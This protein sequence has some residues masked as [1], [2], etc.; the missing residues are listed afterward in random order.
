VREPVPEPLL[1]HLGESTGMSATGPPPAGLRLAWAHESP[2]SMGGPFGGELLE[3]VAR[4]D[5]IRVGG[6]V[7]ARQGGQLV[8]VT[9]DLW[10]VT[11]A[12]RTLIDGG[13]LL[14]VDTLS[15][16][17]R[18]RAP[19]PDD[20]P[21]YPHWDVHRA[22]GASL[23]G[24][25]D[26][27]VLVADDGSVVAEVDGHFLSYV[28]RA[29]G[30]PAAFPVRR[31][32]PAVQGELSAPLQ[33][34]RADTGEVVADFPG[35]ETRIADVSGDLALVATT[36]ATI[37]LYH[38]PSATDDVVWSVV[39]LDARTG[40]ERATL[41]AISREPPRLVGT[42]GDGTVVVTTKI[43]NE[44]PLLAVTPAG[45]VSRI[46]QPG[47]Q[48][49][50]LGSR[51]I[52][53]STALSTTAMAGD[54][55][56][57][58]GEDGEVVGL[59]R[60]GNR[61]WELAAPGAAGIRAGGGYVALFSDENRRV[62]LVRASDGEVV[63][64]LDPPHEE[65]YV[66]DSVGQPTGAIG[67]H[68]G[69]SRSASFMR[70]HQGPLVG[71]TWLDLRT[72][73]P[74]VL[75]DVFGRFA[76]GERVGLN[77]VFH[78]IVTNEQGQPEP[79]LSRTQPQRTFEL[80]EPGEGFRTHQ[81]PLPSTDGT[82]DGSTDGVRGDVPVYGLA[83][84]GA[85]ADRFAVWWEGVRRPADLS[86]IVL[87]RTTGESTSV[88]GL[89]GLVLVGDLL[90][91]E[92]IDELYEVAALVAVDPV[93][94]EEQWRS[95]PHVRSPG[96][97]VLLADDDLVIDRGR[98][99][100]TARSTRD[101]T[102]QWTH[103]SDTELS[104]EVVLG[105]SHVVVATTGGELV[106]LDRHDGAVTWRTA[107]GTPV[108]SITGAG[109][110]VVVGTHDGLVIHLDDRGRE[111]QRIL[112]GTGAVH[113]VAALGDTVVAIVDEQVIGLRTDGTGITRD[114]EVDL[115]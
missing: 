23:V 21:H 46:A 5:R 47:R 6:F 25:E 92:E 100:V 50:L 101:G 33:L 18:S 43:G 63:A 83:S 58:T 36:D 19:L 98:A 76:G 70:P 59:D 81:L 84:V 1:G 103:A 93:T 55:L 68:I 31:L 14:V 9:P 26:G 2:A 97:E 115:P 20:L 32:G 57:V 45:E 38:S 29:V 42:F 82:T 102:Q 28:D 37:D 87:D 74:V 61:R 88:E 108:A 114:D 79:V 56:V 4:G 71:T 35:A 67:G 73:E 13:E 90:L 27:S 107:L 85:T 110:H 60:S 8:G 69:I 52:V 94:G 3:V 22:Q 10:Q 109:E 72:G 49:P 65:W 62:R 48:G 77:W 86:T 95:E 91:A 112:V 111:V 17:V 99:R 80:L 66:G 104:G 96:E 64:T 15:G 16:E 106:A 89:R 51:F 78:G 41:T 11:G 7:I 12:E 24:L 113:E 40:E 75:E 44:Y 34:V 54:V 30:E 53:T 39:L 105:P